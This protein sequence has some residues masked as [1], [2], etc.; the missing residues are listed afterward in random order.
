LHWNGLLKDFSALLNDAMISPDGEQIHTAFR[1][2]FIARFSNAD[3]SALK[4]NYSAVVQLAVLNE[5]VRLADENPSVGIFFVGL[6]SALW[7]FL[8][9]L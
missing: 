1:N 8:Q 3:F 4:L 6:W 2:R 7:A 9:P 5:Q